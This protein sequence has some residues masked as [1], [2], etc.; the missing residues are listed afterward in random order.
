VRER[1]WWCGWGCASELVLCESVCVCVCV[2]TDT[3]V[4]IRTITQSML[5]ICDDMDRT[6]SSFHM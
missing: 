2:Y 4:N 3:Y 5:Y 6:S 1:V